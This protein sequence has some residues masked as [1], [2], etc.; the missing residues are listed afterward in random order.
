MAPDLALRNDGFPAA[1]FEDLIE[2]ESANFWF[3]S[4]NKLIN[5]AL[6]KWF[7]EARSLLEI[8]CGTGF[9]LSGIE[10]EFPDL[11]LS[12]SEI[13]IAGL[14]HAASRL[15]RAELFQMD[16]REIPFAD[17]FDVIGCFDV[18]EH[19]TEDSDVLL[20]IFKA[21]RP[22]G[23]ILITVPQHPFLWGPDDEYAEHVRR[24]TSTDLIRK[25]ASARFRLAHITSFVSLLLPFMIASRSWRKLSGA[26][27]DPTA[28]FRIAPAL[29]W[30]FERML[31]CER[32]LIAAGIR[33]PLGGS[34]LAV[35]VKP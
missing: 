3:R 17:E 19:I 20:Q 5:W 22:G 8:G 4:R 7:P 29:N 33:F 34:L 1:G 11:A 30:S 15:N 31:D 32:G 27:Y 25:L 28:E 9:V 14:R 16:A 2:L 10:R 35:A 21:I 12:G 23:G 26:K 24:Y 6:Q 13:H 18:L